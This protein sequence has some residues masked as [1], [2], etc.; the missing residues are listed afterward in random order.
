[1][2]TSVLI[3]VAGLATAADPK[4]DAVKKEFKQLQGMWQATSVEQDGEKATD[5]VAKQMKLVFEGE[6]ATFYAGDTVMMQGTVRLGPGAKPKTLDLA[7]KAGRLKDQ[8]V[9]GIYEADGDS[10]KICLGSPG[11]ARP[12]EFKSG[13]DQPL[14]V[15]K[16][17]K[18]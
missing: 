18:R 2:R 11:G 16:R 6:K 4:E 9:E 3:L 5:A 13:K 8:T 17:A 12:T 15:Y 14:V 1:M 7:S 10:L